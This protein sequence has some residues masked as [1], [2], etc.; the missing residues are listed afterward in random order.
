M[1]CRSVVQTEVNVCMAALLSRPQL[2]TPSTFY[3]TRF[4]GRIQGHWRVVR[5][6]H[7]PLPTLQ[8][9]LCQIILHA[10][11]PVFNARPIR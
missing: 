1:M 7:A 5:N 4:Q 10:R 6:F 2:N 3:L 11:H 8:G 9:G